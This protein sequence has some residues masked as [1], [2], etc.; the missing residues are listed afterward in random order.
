[1]WLDKI[2][3]PLNLNVIGPLNHSFCGIIVNGMLS[4]KVL[5]LRKAGIWCHIAAGS[6]RNSVPRLYKRVC[7]SVGWLVGCSVYRS[8]LAFLVSNFNISAVYGPIGLCFGYDAPVGLCYHIS[9]A[10]GPI[11]RFRG[12]WGP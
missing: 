8:D 6:L 2:A 4:T 1:M 10:H 12:P 11:T 9:R 5:N 7:Q 3:H